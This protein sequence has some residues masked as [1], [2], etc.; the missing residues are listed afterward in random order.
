VSSEWGLEDY[1]LLCFRYI[2]YNPVEARIVNHPEEWQY[3][4]C[5][6]LAGIRKGTLCNQ[7]LIRQELSIE[8]EKHTGLINKPLI[9][10]ERKKIF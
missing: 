10:A 7:S 9:D 1:S 5:Q 2:L 8:W 4:N 6:D 3:S